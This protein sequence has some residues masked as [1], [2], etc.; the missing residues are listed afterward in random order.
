MKCSRLKSCFAICSA[1]MFISLE[2]AI[3][4]FSADAANSCKSFAGLPDNFSPYGIRYKLIEGIQK[5]KGLRTRETRWKWRTARPCPKVFVCRR[6]K[7]HF[8]CTR[9]R[10]STIY[11]F[12]TSLGW[13]FCYKIWY[14]FLVKG[15]FIWN[16]KSIKINLSSELI[17]IKYLKADVRNKIIPKYM[18]HIYM[19]TKIYNYEWVFL[20]AY[21][22]L[23]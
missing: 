15:F 14:I 6:R 19:C 10:L 3:Y 12:K 23:C 21:W 2:I 11:R 18:F 17:S 22:F 4:R 1:W 20:I 7:K 8:F 5:S 9:T 16:F 13:H